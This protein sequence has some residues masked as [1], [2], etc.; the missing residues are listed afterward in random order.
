MFVDSH[1][2]LNYP[3]FSEDLD[4]VI[5]RA[6]DKGVGK[7]V[8]IC[9]RLSEVEDIRKI[10]CQYENIFCTVGVH[11]HEATA[12]KTAHKE[13][14]LNVKARLVEW[15][16]EK[17]VVG[18]GETGL[19]YYYQH[20]DRQDQQEI[21]KEHIEAALD[22]DLPLIIHTRDAE[23]DTI[24][25]LTELGRD[26]V[27]GVIHCFTGT[28][29]LAKASLELGLYISLSGILTF[30]NSQALR[31]IARTLPLD[32]LLIETDAPYLAPH[33]YRGKRNEPSY[34]TET[35][36]VLAQI[37]NISYEEVG[38]ITTQNFHDLFTKVGHQ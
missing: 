38:F 15:A 6:H 28:A 25:M 18:I 22:T 11:P 29:W 33:P 19:D 34:V 7:M 4:E 20:S 16:K 37:K 17:K 10:A 35:A 31:D 36:K 8:S 13:E 27:R 30:K 24:R 26:K 12:H 21:F 5:K 3:E 14:S 1:C 9:T 2:H 32:R 23:E